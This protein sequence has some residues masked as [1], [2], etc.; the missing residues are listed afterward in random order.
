MTRSDATLRITPGGNQLT[1]EQNALKVVAF[2][3]TMREQVIT[4]P[5]FGKHY[6]DAGRMDNLFATLASNLTLNFQRL[7]EARDNAAMNPGRRQYQDDVDTYLQGLANT[8]YRIEQIW[9]EVR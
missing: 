6:S 8:N 1:I 5:E 9:Q 4:N 2:L 7:E 3:N